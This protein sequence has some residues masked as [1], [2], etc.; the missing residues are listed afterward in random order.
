METILSDADEGVKTD[1][2][3]LD[4]DEIKQAEIEKLTTMAEEYSANK[5][6][7]LQ[8]ECGD[9]YCNFL[10]MD[11]KSDHSENIMEYLKEK[12]SFFLS[13]IKSFQILQDPKGMRLRVDFF[14]DSL[15]KDEENISKEDRLSEVEKQMDEV[16]LMSPN[17]KNLAP[18]EYLKTYLKLFIDQSISDSS[19]SDIAEYRIDC[20]S[21]KCEMNIYFKGGT[22]QRKI[23][24]H[25][26]FVFLF[27]KQIAV[28]EKVKEYSVSNK[29]SAATFNFLLRK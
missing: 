8:V 17:L 14:R 18:A 2:T 26:D 15:E 7:R 5:K 16:K 13:S 20:S 29:D 10:F 23:D 28:S 12:G 1:V 21:D 4:F 25:S 3:N 9:F 6:A 11:L 27:I 24:E 19:L 22:P